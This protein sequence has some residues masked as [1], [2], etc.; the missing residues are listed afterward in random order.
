MG[1]TIGFV[2]L[3]NMGTPM[4]GRLMDAG[5]GLVV[6]DVRP[7]S[8]AAFTGRGAV[9]AASP[10]DLAN[11]AD[12][13][14][15]SLPTPPIVESVVLGQNGLLHGKRVKTIVDLSTTGPRAAARISEALQAQGKV[16][17]DSPVSG[18]VGGAKAGTLAVMVS[19]PKAEYERLADLLKIIGK[20]FYIGDRSGLAQTMKLVNNLLSGTAMALTSEALAMGAKAGIDPSVMIDVVNA[21]SGRN[22][23][24]MDKFPKSILT[25]KFDYGFA[26]KLMYKDINLFIEEAEAMGLSLRTAAAVRQIWFETLQEIGDDDFTT[27]AKLIERR[28]GVTLRG[29]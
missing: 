15:V 17:L 3:G 11:Q 14:L 29:K 7:E 24:S 18:G 28:A 1:D 9:A 25:G 4:A 6:H 19:G 13:I 21:G 8:L 10:E 5:H 23:A 26:T 27:I 12:V 2:G 22:T 20:L 16:W